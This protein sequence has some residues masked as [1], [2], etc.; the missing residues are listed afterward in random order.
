MRNINIFKVSGKSLK[1]VKWNW[2]LYLFLVPCITYIIIFDYL[3]LYGIQLAFRDFTATKGIWGS[4]FVLFK[5]FTR[6]FESYQFWT[7]LKN[8]LSLSLYLLVATFPLPIVLA[9]LIN[10]T[11]IHS[12]R[13]FSQTITYAPHLIS[14]VVLVGMLMVF[15]GQNGLINQFNQMLGLKTVQYVGKETLFQSIYVWSDVWQHT[16]WGAIIYIAVLSGV[17]QELHEAAIVDGANKLQRIW[18]IDIVAILPTAVILLIMNLGSIM[19]LGFEKVFL[20]QNDLNLGVSEIIST[21]VYKIGIQSAQYSYATAIGLFN[22]AINFI[23]LILV[24]RSAKA[25]TGTSLW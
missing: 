5:H 2:M 17:D 4:P 8:T 16:G 11:T 25:I 13:K 21:Y 23:L 3:P 10:Y 14:T 22:N 1:N 7:L 20:M 24:N 15:L 18:H 12:M 19:N 6:F 9:I